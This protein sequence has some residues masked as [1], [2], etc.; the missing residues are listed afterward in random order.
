MQKEPPGGVGVEP[1][2][3]GLG[4]SRGGLTTK[5]HLAVEQGQKSMSI[6]ICRPLGAAEVQHLVQIRSLGGQYTGALMEVA[7]AGG[8]RDPGVPGGAVHAA[9]FSEPAQHQCRLAER[10]QG[11]RAL[12]R[13]DPAPVGG[14]QPGEDSTIWRGTSS[15][16]A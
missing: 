13:A 8:L 10:A 14:R 1:D 7:V 3:H 12:R 16:A 6:V 11:A 5:P 4:R 9:V 15:A 2:D